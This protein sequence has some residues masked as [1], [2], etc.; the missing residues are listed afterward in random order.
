MRFILTA[1]LL[2]FAQPSYADIGILG[3]DKNCF[4]LT[5]QVQTWAQ[6][7]SDSIRLGLLQPDQFEVHLEEARQHMTFAN[8]F[9][10]VYSAFCK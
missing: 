10:G 4:W 6:K 1:T 7:A 9:A 8:D 3:E 2:F 5:V